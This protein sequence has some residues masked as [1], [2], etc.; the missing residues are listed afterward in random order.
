LSVFTIPMNRN[1][2][3]CKE[4]NDW[5]KRF[6]FV[7]KLKDNIDIEKSLAV[8]YYKIT[9]RFSVGHTYIIDLYG[10]ILHKELCIVIKR[11]KD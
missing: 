8:L 7:F 10:L 5:V 6:S 3:D 4:Y 9:N 1:H 11:L 2:L